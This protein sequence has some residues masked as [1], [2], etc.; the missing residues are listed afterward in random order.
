MGYA[1]PA[2]IAAKLARPDSPVVCFVGDGGA[3]MTG[4]EISTAMQFGSAPIILVVNNNL[5]GTIRMHQD[6]DYPGHDYGVDLVNPDF[7]KWAESFGAY[8][9]T[10]ERTED[11]A[12][13]FERAQNAKRAAV[14]ELRV[15]PEM[16]TT[17][18]TLT[19][20]REASQS[21]ARG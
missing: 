3:L 20:I 10:V 5:Y 8:G 13:A 12:P 4:Q 18:T 7:T 16:I 21:K 6:R 1:I 9:E 15:D 17:R 19:A 11:F 2:A 14:L